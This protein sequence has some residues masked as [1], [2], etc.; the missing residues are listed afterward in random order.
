M[1]KFF[2]FQFWL[3]L[4][5]WLQ[6]RKKDGSHAL[7]AGW[8][9]S[10]LLCPAWQQW[11]VRSIYLDHR[12]I[13]AGLGL[14]LLIVYPRKDGLKPLSRFTPMPTDFF[15]LMN[16]VPAWTP[17]THFDRKDIPRHKEHSPR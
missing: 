17:G 11:Q 8:F 13:A 10:M 9:A 14:L 3:L 2:F 5:I 7:R 16:L 6:C 4:F 15:I 1:I 12:S